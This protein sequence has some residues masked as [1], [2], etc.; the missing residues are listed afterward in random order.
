MNPVGGNNAR[1][2]KKFAE[3]LEQAEAYQLSAFDKVIYH[4][5]DLELCKF[6]K[7][8]FAKRGFSK[9]EWVYLR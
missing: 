6:Y 5:N 3:M 1:R 7:S 4:S 8:E 9:I 2:N